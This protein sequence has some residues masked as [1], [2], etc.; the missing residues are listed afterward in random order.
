MSTIDNDL[1]SIRTNCILHRFN[2]EY[3]NTKD[4]QRVDQIKK[5]LDHHNGVKKP[6]QKVENAHAKMF[7]ELNRLVFMQP[8]NKLQDFHK[9][10]KI[11]EFVK[12]KY[13]DY[14]KIKEL[15][16]VLIKALND[17]QLTIKVVNYN[18]KNS[19]I[20]DISLLEKNEAG[21]VILKNPKKKVT[22][23]PNIKKS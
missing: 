2:N 22:V 12:E 21:D 9:K 4:E 13:S 11:E 18:Q 20:D 1:E 16:E 14:P 15:E 5:I 3:A 23:K 6:V 10:L 17:K 7:D 8:W 19:K